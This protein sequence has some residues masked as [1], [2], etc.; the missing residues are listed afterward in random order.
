M[1]FGGQIDGITSNK[2]FGGYLECDFLGNYEATI[3]EIDLDYDFIVI[4]FLISKPE[5]REGH[6]GFVKD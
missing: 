5:P 4:L 2:V 3:M 1:I 6:T